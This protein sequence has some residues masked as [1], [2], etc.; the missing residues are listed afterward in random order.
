M[1]AITRREIEGFLKKHMRVYYDNGIRKLQNFTLRDVVGGLNI[2]KIQGDGGFDNLAKMIRQRIQFNVEQGSNTRFGNCIEAVAVEICKKVDSGVKS[3]IPGVDQEFERDGIRYMVQIKMSTKTANHSGYEA[4]KKHFESASRII[5]QHNKK[6]NIVCVYGICYG[7]ICDV[8]D[9]AGLHR[10]T[11]YPFWNFIGN[12]H[13]TF[14]YVLEGLAKIYANEF[15]HEVETEQQN[16]I[17]RITN[18]AKKRFANP[19]SSV[20]TDRLM[21]YGKLVPEWYAQEDMIGF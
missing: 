11:G 8:I 2:L 7:K 18:E 10:M 4:L 14:R 17:R 1:A 6:A 13:N 3:G 19:D 15:R 5:R 16:A 20:H 9:S 12:N 21:I